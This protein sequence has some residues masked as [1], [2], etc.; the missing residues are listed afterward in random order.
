MRHSKPLYGRQRH[1]LAARWLSSLRY[2]LRGRIDGRRGLPTVST[3]HAQRTPTLHRLADEVLL[4][5]DALRAEGQARTADQRVELAELTATGGRRTRAE[6]RLESMVERLKEIQATGA[7]TGRR[8]GEEH[9]PETL[10]MA[11][12]QREHAR[13]IKQ[14]RKR[15]EDERTALSEMVSQQGKLEASIHEELA[16]AD[17]RT[18][19]VGRIRRSQ[20]TSYLNGALR[21][22][23][24][25]PLLSELTPSLMPWAPSSSAI[26]QRQDQS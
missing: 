22:H 13:R 24:D 8:F 20:A 4:E 23:P 6:Q 10:V 18:H 21:K 11:R 3:T 17:A 1:W 15:V 19:L 7:Q 9:L 12:R 16:Q 14:A 25:R 5:I 26:R 2:A